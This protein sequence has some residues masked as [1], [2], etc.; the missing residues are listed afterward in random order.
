LSCQGSWAGHPF[1]D[2]H[3]EV[4][5]VH[6][7]FLGVEVAEQSLAE[8]VQVLD[9]I[10]QG[11]HHF[12]AMATDLVRALPT[13]LAPL[14]GPVPPQGLGSDILLGAAQLS[15]GLLDQLLVLGS[16]HHGGG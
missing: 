6:A 16:E 8:V 2:T 9:G 5:R 7:E 15:P 3:F 10:A 12:L 1:P 4:D 14:W 11:S 13:P